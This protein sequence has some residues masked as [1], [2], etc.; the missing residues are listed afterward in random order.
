M[1][2][3]SEE[4][5]AIQ[6]AVRTFVDNEIRP[7]LD[8]LEYEG[9]PPYD[10]LRKMFRTFG[11]DEMARDGFKRQL[12]RKIAGDT[13]PQGPRSAGQVAMGLIP[14]IELCRVSPGLVTS[15]GVSTGLA[16]GTIMKLGTPEQ[17]E[18][19]G[20]DL[21]TLDKVGAWAITEP[22]SG[23]DAL[24]GMRTTA[25]QDGEEY[26]INGSKTWI[27][28]GPYADTIVLY[29][30]LDD[31]SETDPRN[32]PVLTFVLDTGMPGLEQSKPM[33]KMGQKSSPTGEVF[34]T[35]VR[36]GADRLL[37]AGSSSKSG[38]GG[39]ASAK[40]NFVTERAGVAAM[41]LGVIEECLK[42]S[43][44]YAKE[45]TLWGKPISEYQLIQL[46][47]ANMEVARLNV[48]NL[49]FRHI[50]AAAAGEPTS[51]AEASAMK[52]YSAQAA[53]AVANEA[54]QLFGGN[55]YV[56]EY[57]VEQLARDAR[58]LQIYAGTDE[59][60]VVAIAKDLLNR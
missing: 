60:Q 29:A 8:D 36:V 56:S 15:L 16:A 46:K 44:A 42:L 58:V 45:R 19:W 43:V 33:R 31:G 14:I 25:I 55:G 10:V 24:G 40:D 12:E 54:I 9:V 4:N 37:T 51:M 1:I 2:S 38:G 7:V 47:L 53:V 20:L 59:M 13:A 3:W 17:M 52:L 57:R 26:V 39:R 28:N 11:M 48:Q 49:V 21:L 30:K 27:T 23:S 41:S 50:E 18:R 32:R 34:L 22:D 6:E 35:D 5:I